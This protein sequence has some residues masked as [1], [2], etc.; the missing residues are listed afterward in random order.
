M[1]D[2]PGEWV[3]RWARRECSEASEGAFSLVFTTF[4]VAELVVGY[5]RVV[6][7]VDVWWTPTVI[8]PSRSPRAQ[9]EF[10]VRASSQAVLPAEHRGILLAAASA[11][12]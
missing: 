7:L 5:S 6:K 4:R 8:V 12:R 1:G 10:G 9:E 3:R 11:G 2:R